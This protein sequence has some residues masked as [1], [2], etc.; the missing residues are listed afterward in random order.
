MNFEI[1]MK[2]LIWIVVGVLLLG[3]L[4]TAFTKLGI[5]S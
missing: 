4:Y 2:Y 1:F 5:L 3:G